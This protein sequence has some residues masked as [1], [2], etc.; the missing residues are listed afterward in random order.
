[1]ITYWCIK[2]AL[3]KKTKTSYSKQ[4]YIDNMCNISLSYKYIVTMIG[5]RRRRRRILIHE[6]LIL[7]LIRLSKLYEIGFAFNNPSTKRMYFPFRYIYIY[8]LCHYNWLR[9]S[10]SMQWYDENNWIDV[11]FFFFVTSCFFLRLKSS[12]EKIRTIMFSFFFLF[13]YL[14]PIIFLRKHRKKN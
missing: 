5:I 13:S 14:F 12:I 4:S 6:D 2:I 9:L 8:S 3:E 11:L 1:M 10:S 7:L